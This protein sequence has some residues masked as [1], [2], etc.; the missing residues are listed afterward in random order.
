MTNET[1]Y[2][3]MPAYNEEANIEAVIQ[4]WY[5]VVER[6]NNESRLLIVNDGSKDKTGEILDA[7]TGKYP[8]L[9]PIT[10]PNSGHGA[11]L[12][13][14]YRK[15]IEAKADYIFQT[16]SD[17]QTNPDEFWMFWD[18]KTDYDFQIG[19]RNARQDGFGRV[20]VTKVLRLLVWAIFGTWVKDANTPFRLMKTERLIPILK[21]I[22]EDFFLCNVVI[23]TIAVKWKER[24][25]W[26]P[27]TFKPRQ[28]GINSINF[29][30]IFKIGIKAI[31]DF[32]M[33]NRNMKKR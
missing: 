29:K 30:R 6:L 4:Q 16:D 5:P 8:L 26:R 11:T 24:C 15:A 2:I 23:S 12:L 7:L 21:I 33:I 25:K 10:K 28:G 17:G 3:V 9:I 20:V 22:P 1:L 31:S 18:N 14:A 19:S 27:I 32:R 13:F